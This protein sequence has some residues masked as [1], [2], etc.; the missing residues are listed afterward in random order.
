MISFDTLFTVIVSIFIFY[1]S[2]T[3][4]LLLER[5]KNK[6]F[7]IKNSITALNVV[8][9]FLLA[10]SVY[11]YHSEYSQTSSTLLQN[12]IGPVIYFILNSR[13]F[14]FYKPEFYQDY[15]ALIYIVGLISFSSIFIIA[16]KEIFL[17]TISVGSVM[18]FI[19]MIIVF[20]LMAL[21]I[22][23][24]ISSVVYDT[25]VVFDFWIALLGNVLVNL[26]ISYSSMF[27]FVKLLS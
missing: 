8:C 10:A 5:K 16:F 20:G 13:L 15:F 6:D 27:I 18:L 26:V 2:T 22:E 14:P 4:A 19:C 24:F 3:I 17:D 7:K 9:L 11:L 25:L 23:L 1:I 21:H 12:K